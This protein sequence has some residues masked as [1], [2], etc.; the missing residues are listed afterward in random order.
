MG[1]VQFQLPRLHAGVVALCLFFECAYR[2]PRD[3]AGMRKAERAGGKVYST[4]LGLFRRCGPG[5][6]NLR[7]AFLSTSMCDIS[8]VS[9]HT[10]IWR[11]TL[12]SSHLFLFLIR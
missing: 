1:H 7:S 9:A 3:Y 10:W 6:V 2:N 5:H 4:R 12:W 8:R 11:V